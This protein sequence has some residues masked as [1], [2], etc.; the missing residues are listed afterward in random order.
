MAAWSGVR[1]VI[2]AA[3]REGLLRDAVDGAAGIGT[4]VLPRERRLPARKLW[5]AWRTWVGA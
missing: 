1:V 3:Q 5:I 4:V 2:G